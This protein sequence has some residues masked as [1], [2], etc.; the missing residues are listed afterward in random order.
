MTKILLLGHEIE[1]APL[2]G[3]K[4]AKNLHILQIAWDDMMSA[5]GP[6]GLDLKMTTTGLDMKD[7]ATSV[8]AIRILADIVYTNKFMDNVLPLFWMCS[9]ERLAKKEALA[10]ID[11]SEFGAQT[12]VKI[13]EAISS[14][15]NF[16]GPDREEADELDEAVKKSTEDDTGE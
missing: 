11:E 1:L 12:P 13:L 8:K 4:G 7:A 5:L 9:T 2:R 15:M 6:S 3:R 16:W 10:I 14:G